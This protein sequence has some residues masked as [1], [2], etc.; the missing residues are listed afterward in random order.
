M[1]LL[2][3]TAFKPGT[4]EARGFVLFIGQNQFLSSDKNK[5]NG[6]HD[7]SDAGKADLSEMSCERTLDLSRVVCIIEVGDLI[8]ILGVGRTINLGI[9]V[10]GGTFNLR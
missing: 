3:C 8:H 2:V 10:N 4:A 1:I 7:A 6:I 9:Q 5:Q